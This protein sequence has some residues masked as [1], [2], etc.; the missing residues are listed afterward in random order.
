MSAFDS[1][2]SVPTVS[3]GTSLIVGSQKLADNQQQA[4]PMSPMDSLRAVF[5]DM[6]DTL[7]SIKENTFQTVEVLKTSVVGKS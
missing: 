3:T 6:R 2:I 4:T 5:D 1:T 7:E